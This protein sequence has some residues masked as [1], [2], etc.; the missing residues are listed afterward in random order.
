MIRSPG[1]PNLQPSE[2]KQ[3][4][5]LLRSKTKPLPISDVSPVTQKKKKTTTTTSTPPPAP[6]P[7]RRP[8]HSSPTK[9]KKKR[10]IISQRA[11]ATTRSKPLSQKQQQQQ[12]QQELPRDPGHESDKENRPPGAPVS[13]PPEPRR[14]VEGVQKSR[15]RKRPVGDD[16][17]RIL[18]D[19]SAAVAA[20]CEEEEV[21]VSGSSQ[22]DAEMETALLPLPLPLPLPPP[23]RVDEMECVEN[24]L[25]LRGGTWR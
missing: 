13:P 17:R 8:L 9:A 1:H 21:V 2:A 19:V 3:A 7:A 24:L 16:G 10:K 14:C 5:G 6:A 25:S 23:V 22:L 20:A 4:L 11:I 18:G 12:Q 15:K